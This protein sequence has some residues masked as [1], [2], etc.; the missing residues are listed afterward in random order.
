MQ[1]RS[2]VAATVLQAVVV[3]A[4][5]MVLLLALHNN[6]DNSIDAENLATAQGISALVDADI[7]VPPPSPRP[8]PRRD[9][10]RDAIATA[11]RRRAVVQVLDADGAVIA[12]S[13]DLRGAP[14]SSRELPPRGGRW[15]L[16]RPCPSTTTPTGSP[17]WAPRSAVSR[18]TV[19]VGQSL[20]TGEDTVHAAEVALAVAGPLLLLAV[21]GATYLFIGRSLRPVARSAPPWRDQP[22]RPVRAGPRPARAATR[23]PSWPRR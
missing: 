8:T 16:Q 1:I 14:R 19:L 15:S 9:D 10:L 13:G 20:G 22:P 23:S 2:T 6:L 18:F 4:A 3:A 17:R 5:G 7:A 12:S 21:A 11:A